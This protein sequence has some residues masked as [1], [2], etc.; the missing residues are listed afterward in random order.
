MWLRRIVLGLIATTI[1]T[2]LDFVRI[3]E[4]SWALSY[5]AINSELSVV[6]G[7]LFPSAAQN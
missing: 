3:D 2:R 4:Q 6:A 1:A 5:L 7:P